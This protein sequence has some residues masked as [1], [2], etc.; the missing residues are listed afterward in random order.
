MFSWLDGLTCSGFEPYLP[1][2]RSVS[3][4]TIVAV[5]C[6]FHFPQIVYIHYHFRDGAQQKH[7]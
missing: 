2:Y 4:P 1:L 6:Q 7:P 5:N 3:T